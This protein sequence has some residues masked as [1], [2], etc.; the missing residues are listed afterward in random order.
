MSKISVI[1]PVYNG[2]KYLEESIRSV[3]DQTY[4]DF[5][6]IIVDDF[7]HDQSGEIAQAYAKIDP[8]VAYLRNDSNLKLPES[9]NRGFSKASGEY[10]TW[11]SCDNLYLPHA[12][13]ELLKGIEADKKIG[14][15][16]ASMQIINEDNEVTD[17]I[18]AGPADHLIFR[19]VVGACFLYKKSIAQKEGPYDKTLFLCEDYDYWLRL[20]LLA[21]IRPLQTC[22]Y[23]YR[24]HIDS[25]SNNNEKEII[26]KGIIIQ[27]KY[28]HYF[29]KT[30][31]QAALFY[32]YLRARD[33]YNPF[34]QFYLLI[35]LF[36]NPCIFFKEI[37]GLITRRFQRIKT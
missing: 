6:L 15:V 34:R 16:Y 36:Y 30:K 7:S 29:I 27:K 26:N 24:K 22:L 3:L 17:F 12:L 20:S 18:D 32:A 23:Q 5:E 21:E 28:Y 14:L 9:L 10:W 11:T 8:R 35:V 33:K 37:C 19:N 2:E 1:L 13:E 25:L 31:K 4:Q